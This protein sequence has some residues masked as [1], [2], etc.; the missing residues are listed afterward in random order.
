[1][2][3]ILFLQDSGVRLFREE[4]QVLSSCKR[5]LEAH[6]QAIKH[7]LLA[8]DSVRRQ[9]NTTITTLSRSLQLDTQ[10][11]RVSILEIMAAISVIYRYL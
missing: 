7:H 3:L 5:D 2:L 10:N 4:A 11:F 8:L 1:M 6:L 9:L